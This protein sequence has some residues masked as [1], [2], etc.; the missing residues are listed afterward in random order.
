[1]TLKKVMA[2]MDFKANYL[3]LLCVCVCKRDREKLIEDEGMKSRKI[4][5]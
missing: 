4:C 5:F 3:L 2:T 1:M